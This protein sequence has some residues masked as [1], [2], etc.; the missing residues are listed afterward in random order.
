MFKKCLFF[1]ENGSGLGLLS[2]YS[3]NI[4][5]GYSHHDDS[6]SDDENVLPKST[7]DS[8]VANF[9]KEIDD[10]DATIPSASKVKKKEKP[11]VEKP[12]ESLNS[13]S[14]EFSK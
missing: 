12:S 7:L 14:N 11:K 1:V 5:S 9:L 4:D 13:N 10:L 8:K 3:Q 2:A 6:D